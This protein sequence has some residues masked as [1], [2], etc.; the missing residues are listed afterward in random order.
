MQNL[1]LEK[2]NFFDLDDWIS[3]SRLAEYFYYKIL[4]N[5]NFLI[6]HLYCTLTS[7]LLRKSITK[8]N[9]KKCFLLYKNLILK[10]YQKYEKHINK[11]CYHKTFHIFDFIHNYGPCRLHW[12][13][14]FE[15]F[16]KNFKK[17]LKHSNFKN[18]SVFLVSKYNAL[19]SIKNQFPD[20]FIDNKMYISY[21]TKYDTNDILFNNKLNNNDIKFLEEFYN[22]I[23]NIY[24]IKKFEKSSRLYECGS[25][26]SFYFNGLKYGK[27]INI[28]IKNFKKIVISVEV[29][30]I[31]LIENNNYSNYE[32]LNQNICIYSKDI[33]GEVL[34]FSNLI[35]IQWIE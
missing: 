18:I 5:E 9:E 32:K 26:I 24:Y 11:P 1:D 23:K 30:S 33:I 7:I 12:T 35:N 15:I 8:K 28:Y 20:I 31:I 19:K 4:S 13:K 10:L 34:M 21:D 3:Y 2:F 22:D 16:H 6:I 14:H 27:I 29:F 25:N 17:L